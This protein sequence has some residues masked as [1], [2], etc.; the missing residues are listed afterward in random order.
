APIPGVQVVLKGTKTGTATDARGRYSIKVPSSGGT[1]VF[2]FIGYESKEIRIGES[3]VI[4]V[5]LR[6]DVQ[7][8]EEVVVTGH[9]TKTRRSEKEDAPQSAARKLKGHAPGVVIAHDYA[10]APPEM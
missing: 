6:P 4:N 7:A 2:A 9:S 8:L 5:S 10:V 1:L 3:N